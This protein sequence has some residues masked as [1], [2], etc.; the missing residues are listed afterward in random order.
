MKKVFFL[1]LVV[2]AAAAARSQGR[3]GYPLRDTA[4]SPLRISWRSDTVVTGGVSVVVYAYDTLYSWHV[5]EYRMAFTGDSAW[6]VVVPFPRA[7]GFIA[8]KFLVGGVPD[9]NRD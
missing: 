7:A 9:N 4:D 1:L 6:T 2:V 3:A 5:S 8:Y